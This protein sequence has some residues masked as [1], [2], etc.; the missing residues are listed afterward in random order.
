MPTVRH[1]EGYSCLFVLAQIRQRGDRREM[2]RS[3]IQLKHSSQGL[4]SVQLDAISAP[5]R[6]PP[7]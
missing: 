4:I 5:A 1:V 3:E 2:V 7:E 6:T